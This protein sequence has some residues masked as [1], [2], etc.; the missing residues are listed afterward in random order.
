MHVWN[1]DR[2]RLFLRSLDPDVKGFFR[3]EALIDAIRD[4]SSLPQKAPQMP[5]KPLMQQPD[6]SGASTARPNQEYVLPAHAVDFGTSHDGAQE[7]HCGVD[8][9]DADKVRAF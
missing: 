1:D 7:E 5:G 9:E 8:A 4:I 3:R 2:C 6:S